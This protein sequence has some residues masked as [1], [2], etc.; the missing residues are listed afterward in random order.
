LALRDAYR[1]Y[2]AQHRFNLPTPAD[3]EIPGCLCGM[4]IKGAATPHECKLFGRVCTPI[5]PIGPCMVSSEGTCQAYFKYARVAG[6]FAGSFAGP[7][8]GVAK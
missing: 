6:R 4:V 2:D 7:A 1:F 3:Q 8:T 5:N